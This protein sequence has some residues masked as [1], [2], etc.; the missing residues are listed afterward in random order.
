MPFLYQVLTLSSQHWHGLSM[1]A[2]P[3][4]DGSPQ[5]SQWPI[6]PKHYFDYELHFESGQAGTYF[7]HSH[8]DFQSVSCSGP[9]IVEEPTKP[10]YD[11]DEER[12]VYLS[13]VFNKTDSAIVEGLIANPFV[14]SGETNGVLINGRGV[15]N[16]VTGDDTSA[17]PLAN[18][19]VDPG[20]TYR[21]RF[22]G[23][24]ALSFVS[25]AFE[26]HNLS[27]I[28]ADGAYTQPVNT[29]F[30]QVGPGQ[31]FSA[32]LRT[33]TCDELQ[34]QRQFWIQAETRERPTLYRG[35]GYLAYSEGCSNQTQT[36]SPAVL[37]STPPLTLPNTTLGW[38]DYQLQPLAP[39]G[40]PSKSEVTR[41]VTVT[42][43][44]IVNGSITWHQNG[45]PWDDRFPQKPYL[46]D[47]Y[48]HDQTGLPDYNIAVANGG[49]D[50]RTRAFPAK[51]G[52]VLEIVIQNS[53]ASNGGL[54]VHPFH[55]HGAHVYDIGSGNGTYD[56][57]ANEQK[58][59]GTSPVR[60]DTTIL[61]RYGTTTTVGA[62]AGWRAWRL[63]VTEP[64]VWMIHCHTL[65]VSR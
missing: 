14:W 36:P 21:I 52:E 24:T 7:Y 11:Y 8:V 60:R 32:L 35:Y 53:G 47:L 54:D 17:C 56:A 39:N 43:Q 16:T 9:L 42:V 48:E 61:Y 50:N 25:L 63:R 23:A 27:I 33:K 40:F 57:D 44:Q 38:L 28:E 22:T 59:Q 65:Q 46:V 49:M 34:D 6:P 4:S 18:I 37:P 2:Y 10:P 19:S 55:A 51:L 12:M 15:A 5:A 62:D 13:D 41:R 1:A 64:G 29:S 58:L 20:K 3:F 45:L 30:M 26:G 31:R